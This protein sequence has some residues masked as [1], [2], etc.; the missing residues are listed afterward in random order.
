MNLWGEVDRFP[1]SRFAGVIVKCNAPQNLI[2][3]L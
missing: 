3:E 2:H 1:K